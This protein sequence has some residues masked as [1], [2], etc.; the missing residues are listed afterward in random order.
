MLENLWLD[1]QGGL[2]NLIKRPGF[3]L[4][5]VLSLG[6]GIG[7]NTSIFTIVNAVLLHPL[8]VE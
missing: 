7:A 8:A 4:I 6:L 2:R 5:A 1:I 3:T